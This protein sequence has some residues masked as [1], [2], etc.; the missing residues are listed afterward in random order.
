M[1]IIICNLFKKTHD[2]KKA[3]K[4]STPIAYAKIKGILQIFCLHGAASLPFYLG[5]NSK[6]GEIS[7][8]LIKKRITKV[9]QKSLKPQFISSLSIIRRHQKPY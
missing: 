4:A 7:R 8:F 1:K 2:P 3:N 5:Y 6:N 9:R